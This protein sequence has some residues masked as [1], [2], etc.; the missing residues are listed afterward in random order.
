MPLVSQYTNLRSKIFYDIIKITS[1]KHKNRTRRV[2]PSTTIKIS[3]QMSNSRVHLTFWK[4]FFFFAFF[5]CYSKLLW[6]TYFGDGLKWLFFTQKTHH[7]IFMMIGKMVFLQYR[8]ELQ[9]SDHFAYLSYIKKYLFTKYHEN[10]V[11][12]FLVKKHILS[13]CGSVCLALLR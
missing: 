10:F 9:K 8:N 3:L 4:P 12:C 2:C 7:T 1:L 13:H 5:C 6:G 11:I